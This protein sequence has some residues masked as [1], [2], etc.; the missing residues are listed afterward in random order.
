VYL[1]SSFQLRSSRMAASILEERR[2]L[3]KKT[4]E[5]YQLEAY[6][7]SMITHQTPTIE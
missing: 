4:I 6:R 7:C 2:L 1:A 5:I 3:A